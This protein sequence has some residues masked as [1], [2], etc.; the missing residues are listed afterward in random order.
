MVLLDEISHHRAEP[1]PRYTSQIDGVA[2]PSETSAPALSVTPQRKE[3]LLLQARAD[4]ILWIQKVPLP[5]RRNRNTATDEPR[6][7]TTFLADSHVATQMPAISTILQHLYDKNTDRIEELLAN[8]SN[9]HKHVY[10][11]GNQILKQ[12]IATA[13]EGSEQKEILLAY[14]SFLQ[15]LQDPVCGVLVQ[16]IRNFC[17]KLQDVDTK[18]EAA[19]RLKSYAAATHE[20]I[21]QHVAFQHYQENMEEIQ[22]SLGSFLLGQCRNHVEKLFWTPEAVA[23]DRTFHEK[24]LLL[25]FITPTHLDI[26]C[27]ADAE[28]RLVK[29][30]LELPIK[31]LLAVDAYHSVYEK[32]QRILALFRSVN[33]AIK[34]ALNRHDSENEESTKKLPSADDILPTMILT[35]LRAQPDR[36]HFN[37]SL[38]SEFSPHHYLRGEV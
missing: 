13:P 11:T 7:M 32:L 20:A 33:N 9:E 26:V 27:L 4:R 34:T 5:Y 37:L 1:P 19:E 6:G 2:V 29:E 3:E 28:E 21:K 25:Q 14:Q 36:L 10:L 12:E 22:R 38:I 31:E 8:S 30:L 18:E 24:L 16:G 15:K 23:K 17:W 35:V